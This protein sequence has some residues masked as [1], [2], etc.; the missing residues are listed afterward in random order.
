MPVN[1]Q[2]NV[3]ISSLIFYKIGGSARFFVEAK[4][5]EE[6]REA[7]EWAAVHSLRFFIVG[8]GSNILVS[9]KGY[10]GMFIR[11]AGGRITVDGQRIF[12]DAG[13]M[14]A[15][16][17]L[18]SA[19]AGLTGLEWGIGVPGTVGGSV[20]G[21]AGCFGGE[22]KDVVESVG[23]FDTGNLGKSDLLAKSDFQTLDNSD[24]DFGYRDSIFKK[25]PELVILSATLLLKKGDPQ[26]IREKIK[27]ISEERTKKQDIGTK[28][29]GCI[30][31]NVLWSRW[32]LSREKLLSRFPELERFKKLENI[33]ASYLIDA[34]GLKGKRIGKAVIS[35]RH[36][37]FFV[38]EGGATAEEIIMLIT[39]AKDTVKRKFGIILEEEIQYVGF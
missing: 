36:A 23:V 18:E 3:S 32:D 13:I 9:D 28:S 1:I 27:R 33:P 29:C 5:S 20:R 10:D 26:E 30:F 35:P 22:M 12:A 19:K 15:R 14:M 38:N 7:A 39:V 11:L 4:S 31:K 24:C 8:A 17:V 6:L 16:A 2:E 21:N 34:A 37:N 25:H